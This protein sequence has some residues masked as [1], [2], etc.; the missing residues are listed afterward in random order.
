MEYRIN[1]LF[2][3]IKFFVD[4]T[5]LFHVSNSVNIAAKERD[6]TLKTLINSLSHHQLHYA[7]S[8]GIIMY[9]IMKLLSEYC[10]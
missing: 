10:S 1:S 5:K 4:G 8:N 6:N 9:I 2:K 7:L 3:N